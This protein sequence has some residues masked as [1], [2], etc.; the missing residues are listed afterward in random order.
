MQNYLIYFATLI[1]GVA[2][3]YVFN[4]LGS[5]TVMLKVS[6]NTE[7]IIGLM[8]EAMSVVSVFVSVVLGFLVVYA[9]TFLMKRR[10]K[11]FGIYLTLGMGKTQVA[12]ILVIET[13]LI[14]VISLVIGLLLGIGISQGMSVVTANLFEADM[15]NFQFMVSTS[16]WEKR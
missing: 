6:S 14:G 2:I 5:Q 12:K 13:L 9:S 7:E 3:F 11:E 15:T 8:N 4:A 10:K 16:V 1:L